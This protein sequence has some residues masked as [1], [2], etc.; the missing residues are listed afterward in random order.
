MLASKNFIVLALTFQPMIHFE[1]S[2]ICRV[3]KVFIF[4]YKYKIFPE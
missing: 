4:T 2:F 1:L 3:R